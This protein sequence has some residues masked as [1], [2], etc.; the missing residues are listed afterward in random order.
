MKFPKT[1]EDI[2]NELLNSIDKINV[3]G[4]LRIR[5]LIQILSKIEDRIIVEGI[6]QVF[7]NEDRID[8]IYIDQKYAG[9]I[10]KKLNPKTNENIELLIIRT[11]KNW[12]KSLEELP[13]WFKDNYGIEIVKKVFDEIENKGISKI[14][15]DKLTTM[16]WFLGIKNS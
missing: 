6:I 7:E 9:I 2:K 11:L 4:D 3:I 10:L 13:F 8:S 15:S 1:A 12:N 5:Q 16:K 14:E